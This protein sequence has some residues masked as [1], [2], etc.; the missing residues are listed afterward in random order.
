MFVYPFKET[1]RNVNVT[2][3]LI[4]VRW[5]LTPIFITV[6]MFSDENNATCF[7]VFNQVLSATVRFVAK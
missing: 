4:C 2:K 1:F 7:V 5:F 6:N 3:Y